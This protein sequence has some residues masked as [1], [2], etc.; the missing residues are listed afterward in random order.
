MRKPKTGKKEI[1]RSP[2]KRKHENSFYYAVIMV[3]LFL[4]VYFGGRFLI[5]NFHLSNAKDAVWEVQDKAKLDYACKDIEYWF[6]SNLPRKPKLSD[7]ESLSQEA[8]RQFADYKF[9]FVNM[10]SKH[11]RFLDINEVTMNF[12]IYNTEQAIT[13]S[14]AD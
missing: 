3:L 10:E 12:K 5:N 11:V 8:P 7:I 9:E 13:L 1:K 14:I 4:G 6:K 2:R